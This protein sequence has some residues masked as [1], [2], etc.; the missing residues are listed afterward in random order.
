MCNNIYIFF[1]PLFFTNESSF[2]T[3]V[4]LSGSSKRNI[5]RTVCSRWGSGQVC[6]EGRGK[7]FPQMSQAG[8][9]GAGER[10]GRGLKGD[11]PPE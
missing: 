1:A 8:G 5:L 11:W 9:R 3:S 10:C 2:C 7:S 6:I 4:S